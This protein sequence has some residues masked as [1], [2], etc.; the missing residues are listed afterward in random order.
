MLV[1][2][3]ESEADLQQI[4]KPARDYPD[5]GVLRQALPDSVQDPGPG[6]LGLCGDHVQIPATGTPSTDRRT[7]RCRKSTIA[8]RAMPTGR[9][10]RLDPS[11]GVSHQT[12]TAQRAAPRQRSR[13]D[14]DA[15]HLDA[16]EST[17]ETLTAT[18]DSKFSFHPDS[19]TPDTDQ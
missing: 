15:Q 17:G 13:N 12:L 16:P 8:D 4:H 3:G 2:F 7:R 9:E 19:K 10:K 5:D 6:G 14:P 11:P 18:E 1:R